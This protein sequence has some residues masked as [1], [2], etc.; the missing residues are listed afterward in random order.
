MNF[1]WRFVSSSLIQEIISTGDMTITGTR[2]SKERRISKRRRL[3]RHGPNL[4]DLPLDILEL[5]IGRL[6]WVDRIRIRT[7]CKAWCRLLDPLSREYLVEERSRGIEYL[8]F[9]GAST[10]ASSYGWVLFRVS[11]FIEERKESLFLYSPFTTETFEFDGFHRSS[12]VVDTSYA[13]GVFYC[14]FSGGQLGAFNVELKGWTILVDHCPLSGFTLQCAKLI[15]SGAGLQLLS[16]S[17]SLELFKFDFTKM[18]WIYEN[19]LNNRVLFIGHTSF[20]VPAVGETSVLANTI[21]AARGS[22]MHPKVRCY[23]STSPSLSRL[24]RKCVEAAKCSLIWIELPSGGG[25]WRADDLIH[26]V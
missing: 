4:S 16:N 25:I 8:L 12:L 24:Y 5:I 1:F 9:L 6:H 10:C 17:P 20:S 15:V 22:F 3:G 11:R 2:N 19:D 23:G 18:D 14:V 13:N 26:A 21:F 7:V